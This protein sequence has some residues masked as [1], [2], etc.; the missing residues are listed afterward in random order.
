[1][2]FPF[3]V[4]LDAKM[5]N[6]F[7]GMDMS[8]FW[9]AFRRAM[10]LASCRQPSPIGL[11]QRRTKAALL[12]LFLGEQKLKFDVDGNGAQIWKIYSGDLG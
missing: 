4:S 8:P 7:A 1:L 2:H 12:S 9:F 3:L 6:Y 5:V 11:G 10:A